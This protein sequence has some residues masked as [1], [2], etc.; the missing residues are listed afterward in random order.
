MAKGRVALLQ[1]HMRPSLSSQLS[2]HPS[3]IVA[4]RWL[5]PAPTVKITFGENCETFSSTQLMNSHTILGDYDGRSSLEPI[6]SP[7]LQLL[8]HGWGKVDD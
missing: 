7:H 4:F 6:P 2:I 3:L 1:L 5:I 8:F